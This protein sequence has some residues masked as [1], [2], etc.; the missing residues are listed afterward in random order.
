[1]A[2]ENPYASPRAETHPARP[3]AWDTQVRAVAVLLV[4]QGALEIGAGLLLAYQWKRSPLAVAIIV[5]VFM[6]ALLKVVAG[7]R[8]FDYRNRVLGII[9]LASAPLNA[10]TCFCFPSGLVILIYGLVV[11]CHRDASR[12]FASRRDAARGPESAV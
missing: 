11:Y 5:L 4:F 8:N 9:A 10:F 2:D 6:L 3:S 1:M 12:A 7:I